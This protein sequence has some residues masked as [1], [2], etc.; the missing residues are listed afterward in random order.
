MR[1]WRFGEYTSQYVLTVLRRGGDLPEGRQCPPITAR[2]RRSEFNA[3][4]LEQF[5]QIPAAAQ[6]ASR[7]ARR[8]LFRRSNGNPPKTRTTHA[9][10]RLGIRTRLPDCP[11]CH[12]RCPV[13]ACYHPLPCVAEAP[14]NATPAS[15]TSECRS[16]FRVHPSPE[17]GNRDQRSHE[18]PAID[19]VAGATRNGTQQH[20]LSS[21]R[22]RY[23]PNRR[24][25]VAV[26]TL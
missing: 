16:T 6:Q 25:S 18:L 15:R 8:C 22:Q 23:R 7:T 11:F 9:L 10:T 21:R 3:A 2:R 12:P 14:Q 24:G 13:R 1:C 5:L 17:I 20:L 4:S 19:P 26:T